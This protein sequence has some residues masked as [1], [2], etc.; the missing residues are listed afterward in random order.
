MKS[1]HKIISLVFL[2]IILA[3]PFSRNVFAYGYSYDYDDYAFYEDY[4]YGSSRYNYDW[5]WINDTSWDQ[6]RWTDDDSYYD[7][8]WYQGSDYWWDDDYNYLWDTTQNVNYNNYQDYLGYIGS[9]NNTYNYNKAVSENNYYYKDYDTDRGN[10][11][12]VWS[13][14]KNPIVKIKYNNLDK[15]K[16]YDGKCGEKC[17]SLGLSRRN[18]T[19]AKIIRIV[20]KNNPNDAIIVV[21]GSANKNTKINKAVAVVDDELFKHICSEIENYQ[22]KDLKYSLDLDYRKFYQGDKY[23]NYSNKSNKYY[24]G[25]NQQLI[26]SNVWAFSYVD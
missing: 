24:S 26:N 13:N 7:T 19:S 12:V 3:F 23:R 11:K 1:L 4:E 25:D 20:N 15:W 14:P 9:F 5:D 18:Q 17:S 21:N 6:W 16:D 22:D 10:R 8:N 2:T